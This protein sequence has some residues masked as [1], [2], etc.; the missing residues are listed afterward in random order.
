MGLVQGEIGLHAF[1][2]AGR[3]AASSFKPGGGLWF[4]YRYMVSA[5]DSVYPQFGGGMYLTAHVVDCA[6][7][8]K[9]SWNVEIL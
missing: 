2:S 4:G 8:V 7:W 5:A 3:E 1:D 9:K 6:L